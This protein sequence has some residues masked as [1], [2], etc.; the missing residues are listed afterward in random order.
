MI[1]SGMADANM[2]AHRTMDMLESA[3]S[4]RFLNCAQLA[5]IAAR[6]P[7]ETE[8]SEYTTFKVEIIVRLFSHLVDVINFDYVL[9]ECDYVEYAML[10]YRLGECLYYSFLLMFCGIFM[11]WRGFVVIFVGFFAN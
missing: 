8:H 3:L 11:Y 5:L 10:V 9:K 2:I 6:F 7:S 1:D 4:G